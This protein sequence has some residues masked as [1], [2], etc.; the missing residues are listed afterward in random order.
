MHYAGLPCDVDGLRAIADDRGAKLVED[1]A[2]GIG[3]ASKGRAVGSIGDAGAFSFYANKNMTT[4]EGGM[5][6]TS[7]DEVADRARPLRLQGMTR[8]AW[9]RDE[10]ASWRY[11][12][13]EAGFK[14]PM[15]DVQAAIGLRQLDKLT[16][17]QARR[18]EI[19]ARYRAGLAGAKGLRLPAEAPAGSTHGNHLFVVRADER[20]LGRDA[21]ALK[22]R[23]DGVETSVHFV[24]LHLHPL[25]QREWGYKE[26]D[27]PVAERAFREILSLP[28][29][30]GLSDDDVDHVIDRVRVALA[31]G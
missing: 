5:L 1:A 7:I 15:S 26:G 21:L 17:F 20:G 28:M 27:F 4:V 24:P 29:H 30:V 11:D 19:A 8:D 31:A 18:V 25:F 16:A 3:A 10:K 14:Y 23:E 13:V 6:T 12:I 22:L 9:K 2:H